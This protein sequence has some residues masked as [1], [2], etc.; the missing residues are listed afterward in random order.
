M[1]ETLLRARRPSDYY[2]IVAATIQLKSSAQGL[3]FCK[4]AEQNL[5]ALVAGE[6][7]LGMEPRAVPSVQVFV[8]LASPSK[9]CSSRCA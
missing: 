9:A 8:T 6:F 3:M 1:I 5:Q 4:L 2:M 7:A